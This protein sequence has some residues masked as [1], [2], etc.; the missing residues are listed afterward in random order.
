LI[1]QLALH[2]TGHDFEDKGKAVESDARVEAGPGL[3]GPW[4]R[5]KPII[6]YLPLT[7]LFTAVEASLQSAIEGDPIVEDHFTVKHLGGLV[8]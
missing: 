4:G 8:I 5:R 7:Y 1:R 6:E 2:I 3:A